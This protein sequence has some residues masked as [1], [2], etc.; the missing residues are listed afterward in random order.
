M[1]PNSYNIALALLYCLV[2]S[3]LYVIDTPHPAAIALTAFVYII[4]RQ[5]IV[6]D[7]YYASIQMHSATIDAQRK[8]IIALEDEIKEK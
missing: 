1:T 2:I 4:V 3:G 6:L 8:Y 7:R 5:N